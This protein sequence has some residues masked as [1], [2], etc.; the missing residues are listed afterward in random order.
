MNKTI[1]S[2]FFNEEY[3]LP[4]WLNHHKDMFENGI[5]I[6]YNSTDSSVDIIREICPHWKIVKS[7]NEFFGAREIDSEVEDIERGIEGWRICLNT[8]EFLLGDTSQITKAHQIPAMVMVD[9]EPD[10]LPDP[11][12]SL[13]KQKQYGIHYNEGFR[14]RRARCLHNNSQIS[15]P[16]G[17]HFEAYDT[18]E[19]LILWYGWSP[20]NQHLKKR[21]MQIGQNIPEADKAR[22]F[23][24]EH[25]MTEEQLDNTY[26]TTYLPRTVDLS[27][28]L[29]GFN[30]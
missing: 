2:H 9:N 25:M 24:L 20:Y 22:G 15:Y 3:L 21:K 19:F 13:V 26:S 12:I 1:I 30:L 14:I 17:R 7:R 6:D 18:E 11:N 27:N 28:D 16:L 4:W 29:K 8:T 23:S 10:N 5:M